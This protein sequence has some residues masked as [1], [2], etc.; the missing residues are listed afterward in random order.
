MG[1]KYG[2]AIAKAMYNFQKHMVQLLKAVLCFDKGTI[3]LAIG[4]K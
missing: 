4:A 1:K 3:A 2:G